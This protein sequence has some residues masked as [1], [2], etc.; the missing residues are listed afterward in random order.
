MKANAYQVALKQV[1][2]HPLESE[3]LRQC[4]GLLQVGEVCAVNA[5]SCRLYPVFPNDDSYF[6]PGLK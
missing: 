2:E 1:L 6:K 4:V 5:V 3:A